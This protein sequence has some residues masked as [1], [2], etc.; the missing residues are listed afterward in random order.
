MMAMDPMAFE[1]FTQLLMD[2]LKSDNPR[3]WYYVLAEKDGVFVTA[4]IVHAHGPTD[5][6][7]LFHDF[8]WYPPA[9][10]AVTH[11]QELSDEKAAKIHESYRW[12]QL[13][14]VEVD[15]LYEHT[16]EVP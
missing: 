11:C 5:A 7:R 13:T 10:D 16:R 4:G 6:W 15:F 14:E 9:S 8:R 1:R 2:E 3:K 12:R